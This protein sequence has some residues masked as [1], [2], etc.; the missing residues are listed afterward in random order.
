MDEEEATKENRRGW[1]KEKDPNGAREREG[2]VGWRNSRGSA[3]ARTTLTRDWGG[4]SGQ[5]P[6][7]YQNTA[8]C[9]QHT[10]KI[11]SLITREIKDNP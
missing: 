11:R 6:N 7:R 9:R 10:E 1:G 5:K 8:S 4:T 2:R 3:A